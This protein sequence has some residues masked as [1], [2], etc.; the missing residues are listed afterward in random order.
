M[1]AW[2]VMSALGF[3][4]VCPG[5]PEYQIGRPIVDEARIAVQGGVFTIKVKNNSRANKYVASVKL[6]GKPLGGLTLQ[7]SMLRAGGTLEI[8]MT[9]KI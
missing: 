2:Y 5:L 8:E 4:P 1:S 7:H 9:D 3:Y 6:D